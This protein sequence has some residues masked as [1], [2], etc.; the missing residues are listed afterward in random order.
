MWLAGWVMGVNGFGKRG[1][2]CFGAKYIARS[3]SSYRHFPS[4]AKCFRDRGRPK[5]PHESH[6]TNLSTSRGYL[7][8][9]RKFCIV[10]KRKPCDERWTVPW[11]RTMGRFRA[12]KS[13]F[14]HG[15]TREPAVH[16]CFQNEEVGNRGPYR[17]KRAVAHLQVAECMTR[18]PA[19]AH[20]R[21]KPCFMREVHTYLYVVQIPIEYIH[22]STTL[23]G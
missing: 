20:P 16:R 7:F 13:R 2:Y 21:D 14:L 15:Q 12:I 19:F 4:S 10:K 9:P 8:F 1:S 23:Q 11:N 5:P 6:G 17:T 3:I 18:R 22:M